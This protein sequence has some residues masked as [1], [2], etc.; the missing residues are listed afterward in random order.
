[1]T[2]DI[3]GE[4]MIRKL[5]HIQNSK[6]Q[7]SV[8][9]KASAPGL[10]GS[11]PIGTTLFMPSCNWSPRVEPWHG[12]QAISKI[13]ELLGSLKAGLDKSLLLKAPDFSSFLVEKKSIVSGQ[14]LVL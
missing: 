10:L 7:R 12:T 14:R 11:D 2:L 8:S 5:E 3:L 9:F 13:Q 6:G 1:M 4:R